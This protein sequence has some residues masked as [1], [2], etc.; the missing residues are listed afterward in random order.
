MN[1]L[2]TARETDGF[3]KQVIKQLRAVNKDT[4]RLSSLSL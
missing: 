1:T 3:F 4:K 2:M